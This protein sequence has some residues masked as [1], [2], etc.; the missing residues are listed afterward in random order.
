[1]KPLSLHPRSFVRVDSSFDR[2]LV[3]DAQVRPQ[4]SQQ[5][6]S[7]LYLDNWVVKSRIP[8]FFKLGEMFE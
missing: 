6:A 3:P 4:S 1:M 2:H 5:F 8:A 7:Q